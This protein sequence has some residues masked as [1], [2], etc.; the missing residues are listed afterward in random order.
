MNESKQ[1]KIL[2]IAILELTAIDEIDV[3]D[4]A[5]TPEE[6][7]EVIEIITLAIGSHLGFTRDELFDPITEG[8]NEF[9]RLAAQLV[10]QIAFDSKE[11][12][13]GRR[14]DN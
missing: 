8:N 7:N 3:N 14:N 5:L 11:Y 12:R 1:I 10:A 13:N 2:L 6:K 9:T 4:K